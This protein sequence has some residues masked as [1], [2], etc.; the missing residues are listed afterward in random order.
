ME[1]LDKYLSIV[2]HVITIMMIVPILF[3]MG[4]NSLL[5]KIFQI[6]TAEVM[7]IKG[8]TYYEPASDSNTDS[9]SWLLAGNGENVSLENLKRGDVLVAL[10]ETNF[11]SGPSS[12][13]RRVYFVGKNACVIVL[14][15]N[16]E[17]INHEGGGWI[18]VGSSSC[19]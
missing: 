19:N 15:S 8:Y 18:Y 1:R 17:N 9:Q 16:A 11:R 12:K 4:G 14:K 10:H 3:L 7:G 5:Q 2:T 6:R 13:S